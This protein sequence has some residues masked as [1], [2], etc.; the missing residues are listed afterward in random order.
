VPFGPIYLITRIPPHSLV[1]FAIVAIQLG[2]GLATFLFPLLGAEGTVAFRIVLS[3]VLLTLVS[4]T[5]TCA[6]WLNFIRN[7]QLLILFG[8][9]IAAMNLFFYLAIARIPLGT[10]VT[11]EFVGPLPRGLYLSFFQVESAVALLGVV[12]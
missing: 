2:A 6:L 4:R 3:A 5:A 9:C 11:L 8:A 7:W 10:A 12:D 1:L